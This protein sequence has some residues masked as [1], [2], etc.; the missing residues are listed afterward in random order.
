MNLM[1][2]DPFTQGAI[3]AF[4]A[5]LGLAKAGATA[6]AEVAKVIKKNKMEKEI[7]DKNKAN[8]GITKYEP[9]SIACFFD[10]NEP[11]ENTVV[12]GGTN[13]VRALSLV[14]ILI[15]SYN[16]NLPAIVLHES[17]SYLESQVKSLFGSSSNITI[18]NKSN[19]TYEPFW[20][21]QDSEI[22]KLII[23]SV[24]KDF[25]IKHNA[26][27][28]LEGMAAYIREK[29]IEPFCNMFIQCPHHELFDKI[30][31]MVS[32]GKMND[33]KA[34]KIKSMLMMGQSEN[35]KIESYFHSLENQISGILAKKGNPSVSSSIA[36]V[37]NKPGIILID[38]VSNTNN[39]VINLLVSQIKIA[40][41]K[42]K[43]M[44]LI[45]ESLSVENNEMLANLLKMKSDKCRVVTSSSDLY[46]MCCGDDK[47]FHTV[48]GG[49]SKVV[50]HSHSS[51]SSAAKWSEVIGYYDKQEASQSYSSGKSCNNPF[52]LFPSTNSNSTVSYSLKRE[53]IVKPEEITRMKYGE[54][55][56][57][58]SVHN[59][60]AHTVIV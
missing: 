22:S 17:N 45:S 32:S 49:S 10:P 9:C 51:G 48:I 34:Q 11:V 28:Y 50:I 37:M 53:F 56:I 5:F 39:L 6:G 57:Y 27:Y 3:L 36:K 44:M 12:S 21:L 26:K 55:Y 20:G 47:L 19:P 14:S 42:G 38:I 60:L 15:N 24:T 16:Q 58:D 41:S 31:N 59:E 54:T 43:R 46:A 33:S 29:R 25:D 2:K 23:D 1:G 4:K 13:E 35:Y 30:D 40:M 7:E 52:T 18:I 8:K